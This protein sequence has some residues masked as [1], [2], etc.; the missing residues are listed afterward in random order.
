MEFKKLDV[1]RAEAPRLAKW[2]MHKKMYNV[3][4]E[5]KMSKAEEG[6]N[7]NTPTWKEFEVLNKF[8]D[9]EL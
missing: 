6:T 7:E 8:K 2:P 3:L 4:R 1:V 9:L 5:H